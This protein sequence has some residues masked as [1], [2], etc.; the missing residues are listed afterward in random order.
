MLTE[1][2]ARKAL[3]AEKDYKLTDGCGLHLFVT[4]N[5]AKSWRL[6]Y[7]FAGREKRIVF[8]QYPDISLIKARELRE[9]ARRLLRDDVDP[10]VAKRKRKITLAAEQ[11]ETFEKLARAWHALQK[12]RWAAVHAADVLSSL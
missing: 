11:L 1:L 5:G 10:G 9:D 3:P 12:S 6:K 4:R 7:R 8:G 2:Q